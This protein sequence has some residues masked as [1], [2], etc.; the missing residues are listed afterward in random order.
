MGVP[1]LRYPHPP[2]SDLARGYPT[3]GTPPSDLARVV[4]RWGGTPPSSTSYAAVGMPLAFTQENFLAYDYFYFFLSK[5]YVALKLVKNKYISI[6]VKC[7]FKNERK[8]RWICQSVDCWRY[9]PL[10]R[11]L[12]SAKMTLSVHNPNVNSIFNM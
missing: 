9:L 6:F 2:S 1:H 8:I 7:D 11:L 4:P 12:S 3:L 10:I 5:L